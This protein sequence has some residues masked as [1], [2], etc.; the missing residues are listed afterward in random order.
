MQS[1]PPGFRLLPS[2]HLPHTPHRRSPQNIPQASCAPLFSTAVSATTGTEGDTTAGRGD[3]KLPPSTFRRRQRGARRPQDGAAGT[4]PAP[5]RRQPLARSGTAVSPRGAGGKCSR[6]ARQPQPS[7]TP[8]PVPKRLLS[9][10]L[11]HRCTSAPAPLNTQS[12]WSALPSPCCG[13]RLRHVTRRGTCTDRVAST[14]TQRLYKTLL[15]LSL[16]NIAY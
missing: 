12:L 5:L 11:T 6:S 1:L 7:R 10:P 16:I 14:E 3:I 15:S 8:P 9:P 13:H 4:A 2:A